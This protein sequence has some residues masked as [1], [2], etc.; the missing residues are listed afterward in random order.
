MS[1]TL[2]T[3]NKENGE[4]TDIMTTEFPPSLNQ[5]MEFDRTDGTLYWATAQLGIQESYL[6]R[7]DL[8]NKT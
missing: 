2:C 8:E 6:I 7:F 3:L 4:L 5:K 1:G